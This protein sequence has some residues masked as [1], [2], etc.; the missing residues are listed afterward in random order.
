M[1]L[2]GH[3]FSTCTRKV[4]LTLAEKNVKADFVHIEL[5]KGEHK[6]PAYLSKHPFGV[7]PYFEDENVSLY[8]SRAICRYLEMKY[9]NPKL[10]PT[11]LVQRAEM[12][13][14][15]SVEQSYVESVVGRFFVQKILHPMQG[16]NTDLA[17][18]DGARKDAARVFGVL[19][20]RLRIQP[21]L[22]GEE[23]SLADLFI[24]PYHFHLSHAK[25]VETMEAHPHLMA[26]WNRVSA[27][28]SWQSLL[29]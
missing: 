4:L 5:G 13:R 16:K 23:F 22:A 26:W 8:E 3:P 11:S 29:K 24:M 7:V 9:P 20:Q 14:W 21:Y 19:D 12:E 18:V 17:V 2:Y 10:T 1:K 28:P 25:E 6:A 15:I 27:R